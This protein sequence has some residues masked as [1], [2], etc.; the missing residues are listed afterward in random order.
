MSG[1]YL[2]VY[3]YNLDI[4]KFHDDFLWI[5]SIHKDFVAFQFF[6]VPVSKA[7]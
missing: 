7:K 4:L 6:A 2:N 1:V 5:P 3:Y